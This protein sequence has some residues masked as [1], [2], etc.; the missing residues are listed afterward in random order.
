[1]KWLNTAPRGRRKLEWVRA[2]GRNF[3]PREFCLSTWKRE[4]RE[5]NVLPATYFTGFLTIIVEYL[6]HGPGQS[7]WV[8]SVRL[9]GGC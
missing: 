4:Q 2:K 7:K 6:A 8:L 1:M 3:F 9:Y 5:I